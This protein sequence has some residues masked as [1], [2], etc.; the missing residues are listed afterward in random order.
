MSKKKKTRLQKIQTDKRR[1]NANI[2]ITAKL[3]D[4][5]SPILSSTPDFSLSSI[6]YNN[7]SKNI[8]DYTF[9]KPDLVRTIAVTSAIVLAE[10]LLFFLLK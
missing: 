8:S 7:L 3:I 5:N 1:Q 10:L 2:K 4:N 6:S 9:V